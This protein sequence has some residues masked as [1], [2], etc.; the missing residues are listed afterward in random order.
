MA[1][2]K[3]GAAIKSLKWRMGHCNRAVRTI[4]RIGRRQLALPE[5]WCA[6]NRTTAAALD[7]TGLVA[8]D[9]FEALVDEERDADGEVLRAWIGGQVTP[10]E[11]NPDGGVIDDAPGNGTELKIVRLRCR[12]RYEVIG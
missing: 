3:P 12:V 11:H 7:V 10:D 4:I 6:S 9:A 1:R 5:R 8:V 2:K